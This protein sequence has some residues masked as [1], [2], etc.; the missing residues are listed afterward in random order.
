M[1]LFAEAGLTI[2]TSMSTNYLETIAMLVGI[3]LGWSVLPRAL[4]SAQMVELDVE[5][6]ALERYLGCVTNPNRTLSNAARAFVEVLGTRYRRADRRFPVR[7]L[8]PLTHAVI[9]QH[10][11]HHRFGDRRRTDADTRIVPALRDDFDF[12]TRRRRCCFAGVVRLDV[13]F[14]AIAHHDVLAGR[15][16][17][18]HAAGVVA[19]GIPLRVISSRCWVPRCSTTAKPSPI[20]TPFTA[21]MLIN[22]PARSA[23]SLSKTGSPRPAGT[24]LATTVI[25]APMESPVAPQLVDQ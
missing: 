5:A 13:G 7:I 23:S 8:S 11:R 21:L 3:G 1:G 2:T 19:R 20:S 15:N 25:R 22:A 14:S 9:H 18:E 17:A 6:P 10:E 24:P 12:V 16:A 4:L